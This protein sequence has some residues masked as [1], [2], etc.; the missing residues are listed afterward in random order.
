M[1]ITLE[2]PQSYL[3]PAR[4]A[5]PEPHARLRKAWN[6][7]QLFTSGQALESSDVEITTMIVTIASDTIT[8]LVLQG[9][10]LHDDRVLAHNILELAAC[11]V[12]NSNQS[13]PYWLDLAH[14]VTNLSKK[15][16]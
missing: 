14:A 11:A 12:A 3:R 13:G 6:G 15:V 10:Y 1:P 9:E 2:R 16:L 5:E 4:N 7:L 8:G